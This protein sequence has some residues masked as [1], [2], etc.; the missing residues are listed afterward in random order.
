MRMACSCHRADERHL[1][2]RRRC[3]RDRDR[4]R[5]A[6]RLRAD[7]LSA[8]PRRRAGGC[9]AARWPRRAGL[10]DRDARPGVLAEA[11]ELVTRAARRG[12]RDVRCAANGIAPGDDRRGRLPRPDRAAPARSD[13]LTV[14]IG[15][16]ARS[17]ARL[18]IP[19]VYDFRAADVAAGG[20]G[21]P[22]VPVF[23]RALVR[24]ARAAA[25]GRGAQHRRRRQRHLRRRRGPI[26]SPATPGRAM[27]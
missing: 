6:S 27:R 16:G 20:Q 8:L 24:S 12:G 25:P 26:R 15:D 7:A 13:R 3:R 18:G 11:E 4:R 17:R 1:D 21:A 5:A 14:Q 19:V 22:L 23:H 2:R 9:C 10:D